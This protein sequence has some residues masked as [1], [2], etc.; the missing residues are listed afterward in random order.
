MLRKLAPAAMLAMTLTGCGMLPNQ[1]AS[2]G[3]E[4]K[5][6]VATKATQEPAAEQSATEPPAAAQTEELKAIA[7]RKVKHDE[8]EL[9]IDITSLKRQGKIA[10]L[11]WTVSNLA[12][13]DAAGDDWYV[14]AN[15]GNDTLDWTVA[16]VTLIDPVNGKRYRVARKGTGEN[17]DCVCSRVNQRIK[18]G[19]SL[20]MYAVYGA[21]PADVT[22]LT[23]EFPDLGVFTDVP[24]S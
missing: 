19:G 6:P 14:G 8:S 10:T 3:G 12:P 22:K 18:G 4:E 5:Q 1:L 11:T 24:V 2:G 21:P 20:E 16:G 15:L 7:S 9:R 23:V 17:A 13:S